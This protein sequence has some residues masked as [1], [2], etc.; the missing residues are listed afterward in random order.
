MSF[1]LPWR[2]Q[3]YIDH[4]D[5]A[6]AAYA[7]SISRRTIAGSSRSRRG[8]TG[9][10]R[11]DVVKRP[12][13]RERS[14]RPRAASTTG[15]Q[16]R[17]A[18]PRTVSQ[19]GRCTSAAAIA[20]A[21]VHRSCVAPPSSPDECRHFLFCMVP[22]YRA[23]TESLRRRVVWSWQRAVTGEAGAPMGRRAVT[24]E[25]V[26]D[27]GH[28]RRSPSSRQ[29][30]WARRQLVRRPCGRRNRTHPSRRCW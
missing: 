20:T 10:T 2:Q 19:R 14:L 12:A 23:V 1:L 5:V 8:D 18:E 27:H 6:L 11:H 15:V 4:R 22:C 9:R 29:W 3:K 24:S 21:E 25:P 17:R 13:A 16:Q 7:A 28:A 30:W 26:P